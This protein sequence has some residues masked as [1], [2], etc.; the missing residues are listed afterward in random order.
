MTT[1]ET[2]ALS[3][4]ENYLSELVRNVGT[5]KTIDSTVPKVKLK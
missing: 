2:G 1:V 3:I 5:C 4:V